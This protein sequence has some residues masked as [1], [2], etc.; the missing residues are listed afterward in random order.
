MIG[1]GPPPVVEN[2]VPAVY[3]A[4]LLG[5]TALYACNA[6]FGI[7][8]SATVT[9]KCLSAGWESEPHC[10]TGEKCLK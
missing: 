10:V 3:T 9:I 6:G 4:T 1:C 8:G 2:A 5:S 7:R